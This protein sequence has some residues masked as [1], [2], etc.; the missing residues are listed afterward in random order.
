LGV[1]PTFDHE[2]IAHWYLRLNGCLSLQN[3][4]IHPNR[5]GSALTEVDILAVRFPHSREFSTAYDDA[6]F[7]SLERP[8]LV[9]A[10][11]K[12]NA[13]CSFNEAWLTALP[14]ILRASGIFSQPGEV[15]DALRREG[16]AWHEDWSIVLMAFG[17]TRND[18]LP[19]GARQMLWSEA[20]DFIHTRFRLLRDLKS[21]HSQ[22]DCV[23]LRLWDL[24]EAHRDSREFIGAVRAELS[25]RPAAA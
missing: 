3:F 8:L 25:S 23:G 6:Y 20:L 4:V 13:P 14:N 24:A 18:Q 5:R 19:N 16:M 7:R 10:E 9:L 1:C 12:R 2:H 15:V 22:W 11:S 17:E 21:D